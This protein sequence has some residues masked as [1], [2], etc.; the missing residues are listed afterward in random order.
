MSCCRCLW[1][2]CY[3]I[4]GMELLVCCC[5]L[6]V[7][8]AE[9]QLVGAGWFQ[10]ISKVQSM[11][12]YWYNCKTSA[13]WTHKK[14][15]TIVQSWRYLWSSKNTWGS[16]YTP[17][18]CGRLGRNLSFFLPGRSVGDSATPSEIKHTTGPRF[19]K[20]AHIYVL[21]VIDRKL[22]IVYIYIICR[23]IH[24]CTKCN[25][26]NVYIYVLHMSYVICVIWYIII[27]YRYCMMCVSFSHIMPYFAKV[28]PQF[29]RSQAPFIQLPVLHLFADQQRQS[30]GGAPRDRRRRTGSF[31]GWPDVWVNQ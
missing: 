27:I 18:Y 11:V 12:W 19:C 8:Y 26:C 13:Q 6:L 2:R 29:H 23:Y 21:S 5:I 7:K 14:N 31:F 30:Q 10:L 9:L 28:F 25:N 3:G 1:D 15:W 16:Q 4:M 24:T 17:S 22:N 20:A